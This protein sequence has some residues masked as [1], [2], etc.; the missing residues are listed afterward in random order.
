MTSKAMLTEQGGEGF[1]TLVGFGSIL[2]LFVLLLDISGPGSEDED[3]LEAH[4]GGAT[5]LTLQIP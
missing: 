5:L 3:L 2:R 1:D 4:K